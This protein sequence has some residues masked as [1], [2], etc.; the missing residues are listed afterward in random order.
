MQR[1]DRLRRV[2][3]LMNVV[4]EDP[5]GSMEASAFRQGLMELGWI[6]GR[7][8]EID[9]RWPGGDVGR[10]QILAK[11]LVE[12]RPDL[13]IGRSTPTT[14]ALKREAGTIPIVFVNVTEPVEQGFVQ[15]LARPG[16]NI[17]GFTNFEASVAGKMLQL[18]KEIDPRVARVA[19]IYNAQTAPF[20]ESY[21]R[22][23]E[24][25][26]HL[27]LKLLTLCWCKQTPTSKIRFRHL[28]A[29]RARA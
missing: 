1:S 26:G 4:Q 2:G 8:I 16:G 12:L 14:A 15:S 3:V 11:E 24:S 25:A 5:G 23:A 17:T 28:P 29:S 18:L 9:F 7:N 6:E 13:L 20:G 22:I 10:L 19:V 21:V 27:G